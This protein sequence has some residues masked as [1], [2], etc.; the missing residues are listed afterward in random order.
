MIVFNLIFSLCLELFCKI[1]STDLKT[2]HALHDAEE[3][4]GDVGHAEHLVVAVLVLG[5]SVGHE[6]DAG[7]GDHLAHGH[8][9]VHHDP[10]DVHS[11]ALA[12]DSALQRSGG[13][14]TGTA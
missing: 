8:H 6:A 11:L 9:A 5:A 14:L 12:G 1:T 2:Y 10:T 13:H 4:D 7:A 3:A